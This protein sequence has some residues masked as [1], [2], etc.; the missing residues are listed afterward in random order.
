MPIGGA[1]WPTASQPASGIQMVTDVAKVKPAQL[2]NV[3]KTIVKQ[4]AKN[5]VSQTMEA[6]KY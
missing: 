3:A 2:G 6:I 1:Y 4:K 5:K